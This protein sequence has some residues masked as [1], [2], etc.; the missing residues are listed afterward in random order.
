M[1]RAT[2]VHP[3]PEH[4]A[5]ARELKDGW[6][7]RRDDPLG[8]SI[9][10]RNGRS[11]LIS[12]VAERFLMSVARTDENLRRLRALGMASVMTVR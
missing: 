5:I 9:V 12:M 11:E 1:R 4:Q 8:A 3:D 7:P 2:V 10:A 6:P